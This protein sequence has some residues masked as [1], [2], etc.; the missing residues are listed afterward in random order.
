MWVGLLVLNCTML[1]HLCGSMM[2]LAVWL[3]NQPPKLGQLSIYIIIA[4]TN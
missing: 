3:A 4:T 2:W 1:V